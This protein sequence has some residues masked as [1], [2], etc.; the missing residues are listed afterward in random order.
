MPKQFRYSINEKQVESIKNAWYIPD[1]YSYIERTFVNA[2]C[3]VLNFILGGPSVTKSMKESN[4]PE[5][6]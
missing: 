2:S 4:G 5:I 6:G 3:N 1:I